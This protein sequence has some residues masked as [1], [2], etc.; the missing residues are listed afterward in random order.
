MT[1]NCVYVALSHSMSFLLLLVFSAILEGSSVQANVS[2]RS[3]N[4][5]D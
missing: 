1:F 2:P 5:G 3:N 4:F